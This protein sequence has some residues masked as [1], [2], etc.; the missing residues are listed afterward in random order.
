M[1]SDALWIFC[2]ADR[3]L[4]SAYLGSHK[5]NGDPMKRGLS[6]VVLAS[7]LSMCLADHAFAANGTTT[8]LATSKNPACSGQSITFTA[9]TTKSGGSGTPSGT[10]TFK[11]GV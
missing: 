5:R 11:D 6:F 1:V 2:V 7:L 10:V 9:T 4:F 3:R 8:T